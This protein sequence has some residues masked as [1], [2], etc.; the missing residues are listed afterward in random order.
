MVPCVK[1]EKMTA[2][3]RTERF[4]Q[5]MEALAGKGA[6]HILSIRSAGSVLLVS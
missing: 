4:T 1:M 3:G 5:G 6:C 2:P